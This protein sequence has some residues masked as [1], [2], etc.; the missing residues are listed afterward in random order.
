MTEDG[1]VFWRSRLVEANMTTSST[2]SRPHP[3]HWLGLDILF[4]KNNEQNQRQKAVLSGSNRHRQIRVASLTY[5][6]ESKPDS[7]SDW[8]IN[9]RP[10]P[11]L[12]H[13]RTDFAKD[14]EECE[15]LIL[16]TVSLL[17]KRDHHPGL[18]IQRHGPQQPSNVAETFL[19]QT[20]SPCTSR[21]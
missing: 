4:I 2:K 5:C 11:P 1:W 15:V 14:A 9:Y 18:P 16:T 19:P 7:C 21:H 20:F 12:Q 3:V 10:Y 13:L 17:E 6:R 8:V